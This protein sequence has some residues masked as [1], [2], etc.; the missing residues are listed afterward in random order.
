MS[1]LA[2]HAI[3][4]D[5]GNPREPTH[6]HVEQDDREAKFWLRPAVRIACNDGFNAK[7]LSG[8]LAVVEQQRE[9][10][11]RAWNEFFGEG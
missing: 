4:L 10:T 9:R 11:E 3:V 8:L 5:P 1:T 2:S 7:A 6:V